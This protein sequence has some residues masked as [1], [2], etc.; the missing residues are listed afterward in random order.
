MRL[1]ANKLALAASFA[2]AIIW[3]ICSLIVV[4]IPEM[5]MNVSGYMMHSDFSAMQWQMNFSGF[6]VGLI[7][8]SAV[9]GI[10]AWLIAA[11]YNKLL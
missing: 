11:I 4:L 2:T 7:L 10:A 3:L 6:L 1:E 8:W 9:A 5:S